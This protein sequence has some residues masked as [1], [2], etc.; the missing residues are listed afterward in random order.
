[1]VKSTGK[2]CRC[3]AVLREK[4]LEVPLHKALCPTSTG[5]F[6]FSRL[7]PF[8][9]ISSPHSEELPRQLLL[10]ALNAL[11]VPRD[12][13]TTMGHHWGLQQTATRTLRS[14]SWWPPVFVSSGWMSHSHLVCSHRASRKKRYLHRTQITKTTRW[15][16]LF[17]PFTLH[18]KKA[19]QR[20]LEKKNRLINFPHAP[21]LI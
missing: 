3:W 7:L 20:H 21:L 13:T 12:Y 17:P 4:S 16:F 6:S 11:A 19:S 2:C 14:T 8:A 1:M 15:M 10:A 18:C 9:Q 5:S